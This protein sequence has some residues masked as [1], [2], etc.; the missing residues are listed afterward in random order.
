MTSGRFIV[1]EGGE[2]SGKSTQVERLAARLRT[3][4]RDVIATFEPGAT[5]VGARLRALLLE[6][7][8]T[9]EPMA[10]ALLLAADRAQ[11]VGEVVRP[12]LA[13]GADVVTD[14]YVA[15]SLAYQG[16]AR[17][18][19]EGVVEALNRVAT[20]GLEP[21]IVIVLDVSDEVATRRRPDASDRMERE[22]SRFHAS[23][24]EAYRKLAADRGWALVDGTSDVDTVADR[25]WAVVEDRLGRDRS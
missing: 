25:V 11:H 22:G 18:L 20:R 3:S 19:G 8:D 2:A 4:G 12:A 13:R 15:S 5:A 1:L 17:G 6:G 23:V 7:P 21:D 14:R 24:R 9:V 10:E 16:L